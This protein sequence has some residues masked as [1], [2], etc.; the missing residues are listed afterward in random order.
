MF[1][2]WT[3]K[4]ITFRGQN[5]I[6]E[7]VTFETGQQ[8]TNVQVVV[9]DKRTQMDLH[10][11][12]AMV[13]DARLR[14]VGFSARQGEVESPALA[15]FGHTR[16]LRRQL[17]YHPESRRRAGT[18]VGAT[19]TPIG[20]G[21]GGIV[22]G[23]MVGPMNMMMSQQE[24]IT[25]LPPGWVPQVI[26]IDDIE[27]EDPPDPAVLERLTSSAIRVVLTDDAQIEVPLRR[28]NLADVVR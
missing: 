26:A 11:S 10:V 9:T 8:Y 20:P 7:M 3:L 23:S 15:G 27:A 24:R 12:G 4:A 22:S 25:G 18:V 5:L 16:R 17:R 19:L 13:A 21:S 6:E 1:G 14:R 2:R 28:F